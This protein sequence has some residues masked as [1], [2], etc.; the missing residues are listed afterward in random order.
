MSENIA[1]D[2][3]TEPADITLE[4]ASVVAVVPEP[5]VT[6]PAELLTIARVKG[7]LITALPDD[8]YIPPDALQVFLE[9]F[10]GP[11]DLLLYLIRAQNL[12]IL[13]IPVARIT[14]QYL[15]YVELMQQLNFDLAAEY[16]LMAA[17]LGEIKS[18]LLLPRLKTPDGEEEVDPRAELIRRLQEYERFKQAA[19]HIDSLPCEGRDFFVAV[20]QQ[21][22]F[23]RQ[24]TPPTVELRE[25][26][27]AL[28]DVLRRADLYESHQISKEGLSMRERM[29][30]MLDKLRGGGFLPFVSLFTV[31]EGRLGVVVSFM[32]ILELV[33]EG[34]IDLVQTEAFADIHV[35]ARVGD[36]QG[37]AIDLGEDFESEPAD[38]DEEAA[39]DDA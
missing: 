29:S 2:P 7:E 25:L 8:L 11:L 1:A 21:P 39:F 28:Q 27:L 6:A 30:Q 16:L 26:L 23:S 14:H 10:E 3:V 34:L 18:R 17:W 37:H 20:A 22:D 33:K 19:A 12:D 38:L 5:L 13:D 9:T 36:A 24:K 32:A 15:D 31:E 35:R 4:T